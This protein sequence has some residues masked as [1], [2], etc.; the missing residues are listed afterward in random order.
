M[1]HSDDLAVLAA[2]LA[3][4]QKDVPSFQTDSTGQF[5]N[6]YASLATIIHTIGPKLAEHGLSVVQL[7]SGDSK[8]PTLVTILLHVSGAYIE[9]EAPLMLEKSNAQGLGSALTYQRRYSY[10]SAL[11]LVADEDDDGAGASVPTGQAKNKGSDSRDASHVARDMAERGVGV[12]PNAITQ[13]QINKIRVELNKL[14]MGEGGDL[15]KAFH[16]ACP[17]Q[18]W[19]E[20]GMQFLTKSQGIALIDH[21]KA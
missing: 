6:K 12:D 4:F 14:G 15:I 11:G 3:E 8:N 13:P 1:R 16:E 21:L 17:G 20:L 10:C 7:P 9:S 18:A 5:Q 2:A 19:P